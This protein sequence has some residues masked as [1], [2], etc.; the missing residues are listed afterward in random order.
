MDA[1][2]L[3]PRLRAFSLALMRLG[4]FVV[5]FVPL[6][7]LFPALAAAVIAG[8][9]LLQFVER[10]PLSD[11]GFHLDR[12]VA[13]RVVL[14]I[15]LGAA[16][17]LIAVLMMLALGALRFTSD[18]GGVREWLAGMLAMLFL[19]A[20]PAATEEALFRGYP[21][22]KLVEGI[23]AP[24]ATVI[25]SAGFAVAHARN[26]SVNAVALAN[27]FAAGIMLSVAF[28]LT[29]SLWFATAVHLGWNWCTAALLD[30]PVSGLELFDAPL[31]EPVDSG[32]AWLTGGAFGPE[33][34]AAGFVGLM[35][36][37]AGVIWL[38]RKTRWLT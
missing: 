17:L 14:G 4:L 36:A 21:F 7:L 32:P 34:G 22:Q 35:A 9:L 38:T 24:V 26:P 15:L 12:K 13:G 5:V 23:G 2:A 20:G 31:Y 10:R 29:R 33:A 16:G 1:D 30:L 28:L 18:G 27:I 25:A 8:L 19:L 3:R 11:L 37:M 6:Q